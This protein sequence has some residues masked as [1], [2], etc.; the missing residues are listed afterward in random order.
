MDGSGIQIPVMISGTITDMSGRTLSG[1][2]IEAFYLS[3]KHCPNLLSVGI[4]CALGSAQM[5]NFIKNLSDIAWH[6]V[7]LYPN[8][9]LP[10]EFGGYDESASYMANIIGEY[11]DEGMV[12]IVGGCCGTT[13]D[14]IKA[15]ADRVNSCDVRIPNQ[16]IGYSAYSG[17]EPLFMRDNLNFVNIGERT[18]VAGSA[19]FKRLIMDG[20]F[21]EATRI[22]VQQVENGAQIIDI[23]MDDGMLDG[24]DAMNRF[25]RII[26]TEPDIAKIP[27]MIDSSRF[28]IIKEGLK[29]VQGKCIVNSISLKEGEEEFIKQAEI[30]K[31]FGAAVVIMAFDENGQ[32]DTT[33]RKIE[34]CQRA[35]RIL[36]EQ[37]R[38]DPNDIIFDPNILTIATGIREHDRYA[39]NFLEATEWIKSNLKGAR[40]SGGISNI[41]FSFRGNNHI[42]EAMHTVFL[43]HAVKAGL[44]MGIVN[45]GQI[46]I[47]SDIEPELVELLEDVIFCHGEDSS[48]KLLEYA[49]RNSSNDIKEEKV[50]EWRTLATSEKLT[51]S[52]VKGIDTYIIEDTEEARQLFDDPLSVIEGPLMDG[53]NVVGELFGS[54]KMFLPQVVKSARVMKKSVAHLIPFIEESKRASGKSSSVGKILLATVKG[55]VHDIG[56]NIVGVVLSCN[57]FEIIDLGVMVDSSTII[58]KAKELEVDIIGLS[59]LITP[60]LDEMVNVAS[61]LDKSGLDVPLLIGGA[62]T[63]KIH[64]AV[65]IA[66]AYNKEVIH[67][68]DAS[69][70]VPVA[71]FLINPEERDRYGETIAQEY[72]SMRAKHSQ[73]SKKLLS[74]EEAR[75]NKY[76]WERNTAKQYVPN[77]LGLTKIESINIGLLREYIDWSQFFVTWELKGRFPA[78]LDDPHMGEEARKLYSEANHWLDKIENDRLFKCN[79]VVGIFPANSID[80]DI[81]VYDTDGQ[82]LTVFNTLRQQVAKT[83][84]GS[85]NYSLADFIAPQHEEIL[86]FIGG[87]AV[88]GG[89]GADEL[90]EKYKEAHDDYNSIMLKVLAD[91]LA[92][93]GAEYL[94]EKVR[95]EFWGYSENENLTINEMIREQY[96]GIRPAHGYPSL[97]DHTEKKKLFAILEAEELDIRLTENFMMTPAASVSGLYFAHP[98]IRYFAI[99]KIGEDQ[100]NSY[101]ERKRWDKSKAEKWLGSIL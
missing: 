3:V 26:S 33:D 4:N 9:G 60:S 39:L 37:I 91:R 76:Q 17:L 40:V 7:S 86:D 90:A 94:H 67:V 59:G 101:I 65:K 93:A 2:T 89:I 30:V 36:T 82:I 32:A 15:I 98:D 12:N 54:G 16:P 95:K 81:A 85:P 69:K 70:S 20:A 42:R 71:Q 45:A 24:I 13:P 96:T 63:S 100:M 62:T 11:A 6:N 49:S 10:N 92:E 18:N 48:E 74:I 80:D 87:F 29:N 38:F 75:K 27:F 19:K 66:P 21:E 51:H 55:D 77:K 47:Y 84:A 97:P 35:Y 58:Q 61:E 43:Y 8:A 64:T 31:S 25:L 99:D 83:K 79:G 72:E 57:N 28:E 22:A 34:I 53:M 23:N 78:I 56:K 88:T 68:L 46:G 14:H 73:K 52:L 1:Q 5:R 50:E 44:D 41:S